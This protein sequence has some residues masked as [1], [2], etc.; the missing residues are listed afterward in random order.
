MQ[1]RLIINI[2]LFIILLS[3][4]GFI[5]L[6]TRNDNTYKSLTN[7]DVKNISKIVIHK[8]TAN[9]VLTKNNNTWRMTEPHNIYAHE[10][11]IRSLLS[12]LDANTQEQ[13]DIDD[14]DLKT[15]GLKQPRAH[16]QFDDTHI[17]YGKAN[18]VNAMR[19]LKINDKMFL[20]HDE[21][22]P[23]IRSQPTSF[24]DLTLLPENKSIKT[25]SLPKLEL[26][27]S[28]KKWKTNPEN[29]ANADQIQNLL[30]NWQYAKAFAVHAYIKR[31]SLGHINIELDNK[32]VIKYMITDTSPWL[33]LARTDL[34]IEYHLDGSQKEKLFSF[35][36]Q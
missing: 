20:L 25:L 30:Q 7:I 14:I 21:L 22:Y 8:Q 13:Y 23:L 36:K 29:I 17:Y 16:I 12:L 10:F 33:I 34:N 11:R 24:I 26:T 6:D 27:K 2:T 4:I 3:L 5:S 9:I 28:D 31:K 32:Q 15:Y 18:P 1:K 35:S 19:Y